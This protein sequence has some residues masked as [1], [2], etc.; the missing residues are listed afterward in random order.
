MQDIVDQ[1]YDLLTWFR[2]DMRVLVFKA[3]TTASQTI[4]NLI[5]IAPPNADEEWEVLYVFLGDTAAIDGSDTFSIGY[6]D[7]I[8]SV[9]IPMQEGL[10]GTSFTVVG[11]FVAFPNRDTQANTI[12][13][14]IASLPFGLVTRR[15]DVSTVWQ[16][17]NCGIKTTATV[18][19]RTVEAR[20]IYRRRPLT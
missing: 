12:R 16:F 13:V 15:R 19:L 14:S 7:S 10:G 5:T 17:V 18:G 4:G 9:N 20:V 1:F 8:V 3:S 11:N 2:G 6:Q